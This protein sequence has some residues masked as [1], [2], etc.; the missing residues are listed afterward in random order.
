MTIGKQAPSLIVKAINTSW[1][2][3]ISRVAGDPEFT[4]NSRWVAFRLSDDSVGVI[5]LLQ[6]SLKLHSLLEGN[7]SLSRGRER[8][9]QWMVFRIQDGKSGLI[10]SNLVTG[11]NMQY[12][13]VG[14][15]LFS[16]NGQILLIQK[17]L[18]KNSSHNDTVILHNLLNGD[19][20]VICTLGET[21]GFIFSQS[22]TKLFFYSTQKSEEH[23]I[24][25]LEYYKSG[26]DSAILVASLPNQ[27]LKNMEVVEGEPFFNR[28]EDKLFFYI[29][30]EN[31]KCLMLNAYDGPEVEI[32]TQLD[33]SLQF[34]KAK[35]GR[36][37][38]WRSS[39]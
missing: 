16:N 34:E 14:N 18:I 30:I 8:D 11:K 3:K 19:D 28:E 15:Y 27:A 33:D 4:E 21:D 12:A 13:D 1:E 38:I 2:M 37:D 17:R 36:T 5:D 31:K 20:R 7:F 22:A 6:G 25:N 29:G 39:I 23:I 26:M 35:R 10:L 9:A 32:L 24:T